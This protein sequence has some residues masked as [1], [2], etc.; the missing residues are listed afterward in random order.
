MTILIVE[1]SMLINDR[2]KN[3][4]AEMGNIKAIY[5]TACYKEG[6]ALFNTIKPD[7]VLLDIELLLHKSI[8]LLKT[9][10]TNIS[11]TTVIALAYCN[12]KLI[13]SKCM[14]YGAH[15]IFDKYLDFEKIPAVIN[16]IATNKNRYLHS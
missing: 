11:N 8:D 3:L 1:R 9:M 14:D 16:T 12:D 13:N 5:Q 4:V 7:V 15:F 6:E 10:T 2:M